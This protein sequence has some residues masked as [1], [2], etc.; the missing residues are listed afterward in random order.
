MYVLIFTV[1]SIVRGP[2]CR[3]LS[4]LLLDANASVIGCA[5]ASQVQVEGAKRV[6]GHPN[7]YV[8]KATRQPAGQYAKS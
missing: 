6:V 5:I 7:F 3:E 8:Q 4:P 1:C 2:N